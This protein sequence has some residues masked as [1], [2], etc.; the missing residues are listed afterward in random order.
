MAF[1]A[2]VKLISMVSHGRLNEEMQ[3]VIETLQPYLPYAAIPLGIYGIYKLL[4]YSIPGPHHQ[5]HLDLRN[6]TV[7][8]TGASS[9]LGRALAFV[10]YQRGAKL[11][12][13]ARSIDKLQE[14]CV[15]L[16]AEGERRGWK[17]EHKPDFRFLDL[18]ELTDEVTTEK[19]LAEI[20][21]LALN[22]G[23]IDVLVN[24]AGLAHRGTC[25][26]TKLEIQQQVMK[27]N[28]LG[29]VAVT[30]ALYN[31]IPDDGAIVTIGSIQ[32][33]VAIP[34]RSAYSA[35]KHAIQAYMDALRSEDRPQLQIL[36]VNVSYIN[37]GFGSRGLTHEGKRVD[38]EDVN[39]MKGYEPDYVAKNVVRALEKRQTE[40]ILAPF[41]HKL[42]ILLRIFT[43]NLLFWILHR[44]GQ[45]L[46]P[47]RFNLTA[48]EL[49]LLEGTTTGNSDDCNSSSVKEIKPDPNAHRYIATNGVLFSFGLF[50]L[51]ANG[52]LISDCGQWSTFGCLFGL[53][54]VPL[55]WFVGEWYRLHGIKLSRQLRPVLNISS[56]LA[57]YQWVSELI[58]EFD[59]LFAKLYA[60]DKDRLYRFSCCGSVP[61]INP[62]LPR[63]AD[64]IS[65]K[66]SPQSS[67]E[68]TSK[69][70]SKETREEK[71]GSADTI[72][73]Q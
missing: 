15:E 59:P 71:S 32:S 13:A 54:A 2:D 52:S 44:R 53:L 25:L 14:L 37:T 1:R 41:I 29:Q 50:G 8:I 49:K 23:R 45:N 33:R 18:A 58:R 22:G 21:S 47:I 60:E 56:V 9:G 3:R 11:I 7:L 57:T 55:G 12:L 26:N 46:C 5:S 36:F 16:E 38:K 67:K 48:E 64:D 69:Q 70:T 62:E 66:G 24:N 40:L 20:R 31:S 42:T 65:G 39:Q 61:E 17:N 34:Y 35:S 6:R 10:F 68:S 4:C 51:I 28:F 30:K 72:N 27:I 63:T 43:P 73:K 19:Q